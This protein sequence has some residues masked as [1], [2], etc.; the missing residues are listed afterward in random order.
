MKRYIYKNKLFILHKG[1][2]SIFK[3]FIANFILPYYN[4]N[5]NQMERQFYC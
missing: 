2:D 3:S 5:Y 4:Y 1:K